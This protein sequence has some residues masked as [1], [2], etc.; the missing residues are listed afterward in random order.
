MNTTS[1]TNAPHASP[2]F[3]LG[4]TRSLEAFSNNT[5]SEPH[6]HP[7]PRRLKL[8][9]NKE[10]NSLPQSTPVGAENFQPYMGGYVACAKTSYL[11]TNFNR[12]NVPPS[13][14]AS[15]PPMVQ[16]PLSQPFPTFPYNPS[17]HGFLQQAPSLPLPVPGVAPDTIQQLMQIPGLHTALTQQLQQL[18]QSSPSP[19]PLQSQPFTPPVQSARQGLLEQ[20]KQ[21]ELELMKGTTSASQQSKAPSTAPSAS[22][23][24]QHDLLRQQ[25]NEEYRMKQARKAAVQMANARLG[26]FAGQD[27]NNFNFVVPILPSFLIDDINL[28]PDAKRFKQEMIQHFHPD[29]NYSNN[30]E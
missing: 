25:H 27:S 21:Q 16:Q 28:A 3:Q 2:T 13:W 4:R 23:V 15:K 24:S 12:A 10:M 1:P 9:E 30:N 14:D 11:L 22:S 20:L 17:P 5:K 7:N 19:M 29:N 6:R 8:P 26:Y 18:Q